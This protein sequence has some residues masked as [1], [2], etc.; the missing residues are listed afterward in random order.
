MGPAHKAKL[1][2]PHR[3]ARK[4]RRQVQSSMMPSGIQVCQSRQVIPTRLPRSPGP[5]N[6][7]PRTKTWATARHRI[8]RPVMRAKLRAPHPTALKPRRQAPSSMMPSGVQVCQN[9]RV[10]LTHVPRSPGPQ[11]RHRHRKTPLTLAQGRMKPAQ[12]AKFPRSRLRP[13]KTTYRQPPEHP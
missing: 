1:R 2:A 4:L 9:R 8:M 10:I 6:Q 11:N 3:T 5:P 12:K 13:P 7:R